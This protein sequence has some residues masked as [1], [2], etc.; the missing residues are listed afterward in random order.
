MSQTGVKILTIDSL[1]KLLAL[2]KSE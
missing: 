1:L 2:K